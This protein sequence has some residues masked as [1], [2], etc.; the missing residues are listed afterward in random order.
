MAA[1]QL[2]GAALEVAAAAFFIF[3]GWSL[4]TRFPTSA[5]ARPAMVLFGAYWLSIGV[6]SA[7]K[8][9]VLALTG[10]SVVPGVLETIFVTAHASILFGIAA[11]MFYIT[12]ILA[13]KEGT[14]YAVFAVYLLF[15]AGQL[16]LTLRGG[17]V[18][19][20]AAFGYPFYTRADNGI[21]PPQ[22]AYL[23]ALAPFV[24]GTVGLLYLGVQTDRTHT[25]YRAMLVGGALLFWAIASGTELNLRDAGVVAL[26]PGTVA[27]VAA[28][29]VYVAYFPPGPI[30]RFLEQREE[31]RRLARELKGSA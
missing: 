3:T 1:G 6:A 28:V 31:N 11:F 27:L 15:G 14:A 4:M 16:V 2:V 24:F 23:V 17:F 20:D 18:D 5:R 30:R 10:T 9:A 21:I 8:F 19:T 7:L 29:A 26:A 13:G 25:R 22:I 12:Y